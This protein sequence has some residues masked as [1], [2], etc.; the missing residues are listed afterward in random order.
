[1]PLSNDPS[2]LLSQPYASVA[3]DIG[4][5]APQSV[6]E[7]VEEGEPDEQCAS[8]QD[9]SWEVYLD[10]AGCIKTL[11]VYAARSAVLPYGLTADMLPAD[12]VSILG[13]PTSSTPE[14]AVPILGQYGASCRWDN[15][16]FCLHA[17]FHTKGGP[18]KML[19]FMLPRNAPKVA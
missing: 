13:A 14:Q 12:V 9:G 7:T 8:A 18:L 2:A 3:L 10:E 5:G 6:F 15:A 19:T 16:Q 4:G 1:M 11:F 17:Q